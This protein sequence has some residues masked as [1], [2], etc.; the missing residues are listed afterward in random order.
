MA[1]LK[2]TAA[3][4]LLQVGSNT[5]SIVIPE[6]TPKPFPAPVPTFTYALL[7]PL[8]DN[9]P[10]TPAPLTRVTPVPRVPWFTLLWS[11]AGAPS[12]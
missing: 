12:S 8:S 11:M 2:I 9:A 3:L 1:F 10:P 5:A 7:V 4:L 6:L